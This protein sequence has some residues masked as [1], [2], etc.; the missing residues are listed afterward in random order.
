M[1]NKL[2]KE[3]LAAEAEADIIV[4]DAREKSAQIVTSAKRQAETIIEEL[5]KKANI[6]TAQIL[7]SIETDERV[8]KKY[9]AEFSEKAKNLKAEA[10]KKYAKVADF[11]VGAVVQKYSGVEET[12]AKKAPAKASASKATAKAAPKTTASKTTAKKPAKK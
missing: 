10:T 5:A 3:I 4:K 7:S 2:I 11:I 6:E 12:A 9:E 8:I 1:Q